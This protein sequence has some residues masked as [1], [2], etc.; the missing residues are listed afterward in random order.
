M[1]K[2]TLK[3]RNP[4]DLI[5]KRTLPVRRKQALQKAQRDELGQ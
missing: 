5:G 2:L 1:T 4:I 3:P